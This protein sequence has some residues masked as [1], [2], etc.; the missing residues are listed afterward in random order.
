MRRHS[1]TSICLALVAML[2][3]PGAAG[4]QDTGISGTVSDTTGGILPGVTVEVRDAD[5]GVQTAFTDGTG[6]FSVSLQ[7]GTYNVTI[8]LPGFT[9]VEQE[10]TVAAGAMVTVNAELGI[11]FAETVAVVGTRSEPRS[12]TASPVPVDV[13]TA[14]DFISQG[15]IDLT[16]QLRTVVPSFN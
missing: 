13:I 9:V 4:A 2:L 3:A 14:Q 8:T 15:D 12:I 10:V 6:M 5:G 16:N 7:P 1:Y 11:E